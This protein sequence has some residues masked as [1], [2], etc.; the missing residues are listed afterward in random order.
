[1]V[2]A[3]GYE[4]SRTTQLGNAAVFG[5]DGEPEIGLAG[6]G[7]HA[8]DPGYLALAW[9]LSAGDKVLAARNGM[10]SLRWIDMC[11]RHALDVQIVETPWGQGIPADRFE[12][13]LR[14]DSGHKIKVVLATHNETATGVKSDIAAVRK[15]LD[16]ANHPALFFVDA[17]AGGF[18]GSAIFAYWFSERF[19][20]TAAMV[21]IRRSDGA[22]Q[23]RP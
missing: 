19:G 12:E 9:S 23:L 18:V 5:A 20:A 3:L 17:F 21:A 10:F 13:V 8:A 11:Q 1:M 16:A 7:V 14:A 4:Q 2:G 6:D 15:A 22:T